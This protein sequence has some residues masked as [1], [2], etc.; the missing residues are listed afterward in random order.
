MNKIVYP[1]LLTVIIALTIFQIY[2]K[3]SNTQ[4]VNY[5]K[6]IIESKN[7]T[8]NNLLKDNLFDIDNKLYAYIRQCD[9]T[10]L[11]NDSKIKLCLYLSA[12][13]HCDACIQLELKTIRKNNLQNDVCILCASPNKAY[14]NSFRNLNKDIPAIRFCSVYN[15]FSTFPTYFVIKD[16]IIKHIYQ[17]DTN[18][19]GGPVNYFLNTIHRLMQ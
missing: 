4:L 2:E 7:I 13:E 1:L 16:G 14:V 12:E 17:S 6:E 9:S 19:H 8:I 15:K 18:H 11:Q 10:L 5:M 3:R